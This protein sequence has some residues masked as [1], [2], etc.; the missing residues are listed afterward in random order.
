MTISSEEVERKLAQVEARIDKKFDKLIDASAST[1]TSI[2][3]LSTKITELVTKFDASMKDSERI[4]R[5]Q[6]DHYK[7]LE[8]LGD[9][10]VALE[11][12]QEGLIQLALKI[13]P[14]VFSG[15]AFIGILK[16]LLEK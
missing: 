11:T 10:V 16:V 4:E 13:M 8:S 15:G 12:R 14:I 7:K 2:G 3:G 1:T 5:N 9:R 6:N